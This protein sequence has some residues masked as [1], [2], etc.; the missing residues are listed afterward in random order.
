MDMAPAT[1]HF[2]LS[3]FCPHSCLNALEAPFTSLPTTHGLRQVAGWP[4]GTQHPP[5][6]PGPSRT[7]TLPLVPLCPSEMGQDL[8]KVGHGQRNG[9]HKQLHISDARALKSPSQPL[10]SHLGSWSMAPLPQGSPSP[11][12]AFGTEKPRASPR[13]L[14]LWASSTPLWG[15]RKQAA[16]CRLGMGKGK[17]RQEQNANLYFHKL[18]CHSGELTV[19]ARGAMHLG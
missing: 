19:V 15:W 9:K 10:G 4:L 8:E 1:P 14:L 2:T 13:Q 12:R 7:R 3:C 6:C 18:S 11:G 16:G 5:E 17:E